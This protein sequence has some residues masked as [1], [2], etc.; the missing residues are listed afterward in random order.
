MA[1]RRIFAQEIETSIA[2]RRKWSRSAIRLGMAE[3]QMLFPDLT[4]LQVRD[5]L[6][7]I[8]CQKVRKRRRDE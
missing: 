8:A 6:W 1:L 2:E 3:V 5:K 7:T 4:E